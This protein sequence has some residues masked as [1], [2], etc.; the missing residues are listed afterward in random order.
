MI[1]NERV[2][3]NLQGAGNPAN[4]RMDSSERKVT[5]QDYARIFYRGRYA[6]LLTFLIIFL[7]SAVITFSIK[8]V[9]EASVRLM[10]IDQS[11]VGQSLFDFTSMITK[12]TLINNQVEILKSRT[13]GEY[14]MKDLESSKYAGQLELLYP[15]TALGRFSPARIFFR[16]PAKQNAGRI[17]DNKVQQLR[18]N[19]SIRHL[20]STDM[21]EIKF[22]AHS[23]FESYYVANEIAAAYIRINQAESQAEV[24]QVKDFLEQQLATYREELQ[25]SEEALKA[26]QEQAKV[27]ALDSETAELV[28][29]IA[30]FETL[31]NAAKTDLEAARHRLV[32]INDE[33]EK[34]NTNFDIEVIYKTTALEEFTKKIAEKES[35]LAVYQ[36]QTIQKGRS[37]STLQYTLREIENL[38]NQIDALKEQFREDVTAVAANQF[39]DPAKISS[40]LFDSKIAVETEIHALEPKVEAFG[41]ILDRYNLELDSLPTKKLQLARLMRSAQ[42]AEKLYVMLEEKYQESRITEVGQIGNVRIIDP[43]KE[44]EEPIM[45]K[46]KLNLLLGMLLGLAFGVT[47]AFVIEYMDDTV[48]TM[49]DLDNLSMPL[50]ATI[51]YIKPEQSNGFIAKMAKLD[52]PEVNAINERLVTH[53]KPKSPVSEAYR[54]LRTNIIFTAPDNPKNIIL[55]TSTGPQEGKSTSVANLAITFA[56][57]GAKTLLIDADLRR[58]MLHKLFQVNQQP[59][60]TNA[61][62]GRD[63]LVDLI[64]PVDAVPGLELLT[65]GINPPNP[66]EL[67]GSGRMNELLEEARSEYEIILIDTPPVIAVTDPSVLARYVDGVVVVVKTAATQRS[68]A[69][70]AAE[71]LRRVNAPILGVLLNGITTTNFYG[72]FYYQKYYYYYSNDGEKKRRKNRKKRMS[73]A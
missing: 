22:K 63:K 12:E 25:G 58:P 26:Y 6:T 21:V 38:T 49:E 35:Q 18:D 62:V 42:V 56:Q 29:K 5:W 41:K 3:P 47:I 39:V 50:I 72:S 8:P 10:L 30:E 53:L 15:D 24:R 46:K 57:A 48:R 70:M 9:Y 27:V 59:G 65:C 16:T 44:P 60:L 33:L 67:L 54:T 11:S 61:L 43:A 40:S 71:Q 28:R 13:H 68:A 66:A 4:V 51:P 55:V 31:F 1:K 34:Q 32:Y 14:V 19:M 52:D 23:P 36:A 20:R 17:F 45:P 37:E 7:G 69:L 73:S 64:T 2:S